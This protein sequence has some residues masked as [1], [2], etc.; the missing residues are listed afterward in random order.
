MDI[1]GGFNI[2][3]QA[4]MHQIA[5]KRNKTLIFSTLMVTVRK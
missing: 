3:M 5:L 1:M 4:G 2:A